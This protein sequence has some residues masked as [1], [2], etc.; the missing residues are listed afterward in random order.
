VS[1][2]TQ[3]IVLPP[4][5]AAR[6]PRTEVPRGEKHPRAG[7]ALT[8]S[9]A[10]LLVWPLAL[11]GI[12]LADQVR[13]DAATTPRGYRNERVAAAA[14]ILGWVFVALGIFATALVLVL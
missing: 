10:G 7:L 2:Q 1:Q 4:L 8:L 13:E 14:R 5:T 9:L 11:G 6:L 12:I 3:E